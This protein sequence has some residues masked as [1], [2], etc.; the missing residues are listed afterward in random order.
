M[1]QTPT[2][3]ASLARI[4]VT[5]IDTYVYVVFQNGRVDQNYFFTLNRS[6]KK[7]QNFKI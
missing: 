7:Y 5:N 2:T 1:S 3:G 4:L 6:A